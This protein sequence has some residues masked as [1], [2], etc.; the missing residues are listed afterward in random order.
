MSEHFDSSFE[1]IISRLKDVGD[2]SSSMSLTDL[3]MVIMRLN[4]TAMFLSEYMM[5]TYLAPEDYIFPQEL[6]TQ[7]PN[8]IA[9]C[10][11]V[12]NSIHDITCEDCKDCD[13][14]DGCPKCMDP[15]D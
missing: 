3:T 13:C 12:S 1:D 14:E 11:D 8:L 5:L 9:L 2:A 7:I 6:N 15:E 4:E 10:V